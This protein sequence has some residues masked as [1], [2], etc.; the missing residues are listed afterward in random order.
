M[1]KHDHID[2][3]LTKHWRIAIRIHLYQVYVDTGN[4]QLLRSELF[5][6]CNIYRW[7]NAAAPGKEVT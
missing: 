5:K 7:P 6:K 4:S 2:P 1:I 3:Y